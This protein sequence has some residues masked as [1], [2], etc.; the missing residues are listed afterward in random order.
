[1]Y[2]LLR[3]V[4]PAW[5]FFFLLLG[6]LVHFFV[7]AAHVITLSYPIVG[8]ALLV[9]GLVFTMY[10]SSLF[11]KE[12][13]EILPTSVTNRMLITYGPFHYSRNPMYLGL[14]IGLL[15]AAMWV[16]TLPVYLATIFYFCVLNFAFI[17]FEESKLS[18]IFGAEFE[19]YRQKVRRWL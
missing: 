12:K 14:V 13:T 3:I 18:R 8:I 1:M 2:T 4:P 19:A 9:A 7:P 11:A 5:F 16:G 17:P 15:G 10:S 6:L